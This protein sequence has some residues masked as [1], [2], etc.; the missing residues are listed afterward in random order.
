MAAAVLRMGAVA[1]AVVLPDTG[2]TTV[3]AAGAL[4]G[5]GRAVEA[6]VRARGREYER[7]TGAF[8]LTGSR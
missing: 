2:F 5:A 4:V 8:A 3:F 6:V 7:R 1:L